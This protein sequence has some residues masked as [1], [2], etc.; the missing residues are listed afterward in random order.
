[1]G[2][3]AAVYAEEVGFESYRFSTPIGF[4]VR[5][6]VPRRFKKYSIG[7]RITHES[8]TG[9]FSSHAKYIRYAHYFAEREVGILSLQERYMF[10]VSRRPGRARCDN[11]NIFE[12]LT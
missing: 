6:S 8:S 1:M 7:F 2:Y 3:C 11:L 4:L 5:S 9:A 10:R 12:S